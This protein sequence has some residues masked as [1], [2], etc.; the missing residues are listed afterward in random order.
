VM[1]CVD[2]SRVCASVCRVFGVCRFHTCVGVAVCCSVL[3]CAA[4]WCSVLW[5]VAAWCSVLQYRVCASVCTVCT[6][7]GVSRVHMCVCVAV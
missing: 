6:V 4:A 5:R 1:Q 3:Q 7:C 2:V